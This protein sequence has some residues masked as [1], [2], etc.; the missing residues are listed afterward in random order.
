MKKFNEFYRIREELANNQMAIEWLEANG[1]EITK[2]NINILLEAGMFD[3]IKQFGKKAVIPLG[4]AASL[5]G[6]YPQ[7]PSSVPPPHAYNY[8]IDGGIQG[9]AKAQQQ[10]DA[11]LKIVNQGGKIPNRDSNQP[12]EVNAFDNLVNDGLTDK[13][14]LQD[15]FIQVIQTKNTDKGTLCVIVAKGKV[16]ADSKEEAKIMVQRQINALKMDNGMDTDVQ[17]INDPDIQVQDMGT[18]Q[19]EA[20]G[21]RAFIVH[22]KGQVLVKNQGNWKADYWGFKRK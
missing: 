15:Q 5:S 20:V 13:L 8:N 17:F 22:I 9:D 4:M 11:D 3:R 10:Y 19:S 1:Y 6:G 7:A 18:P 21:Q 16:Y 12:T 14:G 2:T